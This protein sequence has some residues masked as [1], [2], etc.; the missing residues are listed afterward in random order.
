M[1]ASLLAIGVNR[2]YLLAF[3]W[4]LGVE[5]WGP[6]IGRPRILSGLSICLFAP[7]FRRPSIPDA[8]EMRPYLAVL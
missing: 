2:R 7:C 3:H 4:A 8:S 6:A 1:I 5:R